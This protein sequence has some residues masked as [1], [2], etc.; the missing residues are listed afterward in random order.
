MSARKY[1][2]RL[3]STD[4]K[5]SAW[6]TGAESEKYKKR[7]YVNGDTMERDYDRR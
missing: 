7:F 1:Q 3:E 2:L 6:R 4:D 5:I